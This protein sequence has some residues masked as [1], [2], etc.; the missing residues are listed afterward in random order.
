[1]TAPAEA[2]RL[3]QLLGAGFGIAVAVGSM[4]GAGIL[5]APADVAARLPVPAL[6]LG[7]WLLGGAY[8]LLGA[9]AL[10]ELSTMTPRS[11]GQ[12][13]FARRA[14][15]PFAGFLVGWNDWL[16]CSAAV[17]AVGF[18]FGEAVRTLAAGGPPPGTVA[19]LAVTVLALAVWR[20][21]KEGARVQAVTSLSKGAVLVGLVLLCAWHAATRG[22][23]GST[24]SVPMA[25]GSL[26]VAFVLS[27]QGVIYAYDGWTGVVYFAEE[28]TNP[29][30]DIPRALFGGVLSVLGL[31]L[32]IN[33]AFMLV[34]PLADMA[35]APLAAVSV[36]ERVVGGWGGTLVNV[37]I[38]AVL[39]SSIIANLLMGSRASFALARD[40]VAPRALLRVN[41][42][43]TPT[44]S[45]GI[46]AGA[47]MLLLLTGT[48][49]R[50][51]ALAAFLF[52]A[53][54][55]LSF[56]GLFALRRRE[57]DAPRPWRARGHPWTT[58][59]AL[60]GSVVFLVGV[61]AADPVNGA[62]AL[63]LVAASGPVWA[64]LRR[65]RRPATSDQ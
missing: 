28:V 43:G 16:A 9:N 62:I 46:T 37:I 22:S 40:G 7:V 32:L 36:A 45:L 27:L 35:R 63:T 61:V 29:S 64:V 14:F 13:V 12:M 59:F 33:L 23:S 58:A 60:A 34:L 53:G 31:Y 15:G 50:A 4:I 6:F 8:A 30:R 41:A 52:V 51:I 17:A 10:A 47:G 25:D 57:P 42:G 65:R 48:F 54:Y 26:L 44:A 49:E 38:V 55:T 5:R 11:G 56:A 19:A 24:T 18:V 2:H 20:G 1:M 21:A 39:P 3:R